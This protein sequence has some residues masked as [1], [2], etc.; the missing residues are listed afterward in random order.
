MESTPS[1]LLLRE[2]PFRKENGVGFR[3]VPG[4]VRGASKGIQAAS[5][6]PEMSLAALRLKWGCGEPCITRWVCFSETFPNGYCFI[7]G[8]VGQGH[9]SR[10][11][12]SSRCLP[13]LYP[14]RD[15]AKATGAARSLAPLASPRLRRHALWG[16]RGIEPEPKPGAP[17]LLHHPPH[18]ILGP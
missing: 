17:T 14:P 7:E 4:G 3:G 16:R 12:G 5:T 18:P 10:K 1:P 2:Q 13:C 6:L 9:F 8:L 15:S 11:S